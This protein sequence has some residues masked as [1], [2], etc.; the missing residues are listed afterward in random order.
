M[1]DRSA[2][3]AATSTAAGTAD[4]C[5][6]ERSPPVWCASA[7]LPS[8]Q[9]HDRPTLRRSNVTMLAGAPRYNERKSH[10]PAFESRSLRAISADS[11]RRTPLFSNW[12]T[13]S[14]PWNTNPTG[15]FTY[16]SSWNT[17]SAPST[18]Y[19]NAW[20]TNAGSWNADTNH[21]NTNTGTKNT[22]S[23]GCRAA[24]GAPTPSHSGRTSVRS[25]FL[26]A[27]RCSHGG[28]GRRVRRR[29]F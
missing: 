24:A 17:Y 25:S 18:T 21:W 4:R 11:A 1:P 28:R 29:C 23:N 10:C 14:V 26:T 22:D 2:R 16:F 9:Q 27:P 19:S 12:H 3:L 20:Y 6:E 15:S 5:G 13:D 7:P 8:K